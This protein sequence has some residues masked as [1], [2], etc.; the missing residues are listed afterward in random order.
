MPNRGFSMKQ[1]A[2]MINGILGR[3]VLTEHQLHQIM[4]GAKR[5]NQEGG[6]NAVLDYLIKVTQADVDKRELQK[7]AD[8]IQANPRLGL[9]ILKGRKSPN[10]RRRK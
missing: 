3:N 6:M 1:L 5:A 8:H 7:F 4:E 10:L 2:D 9:E